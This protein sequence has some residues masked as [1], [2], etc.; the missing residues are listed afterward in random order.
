VNE[1][2]IGFKST[3]QQHS[4]WIYV[5]TNCN[6]GSLAGIVKCFQVYHTSFFYS[7]S[8]LKYYHI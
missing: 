8:K 5:N 6:H 4:P 7:T 3:D 1:L 2:V